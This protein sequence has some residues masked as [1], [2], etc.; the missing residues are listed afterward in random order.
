M[1]AVSRTRNQRAVLRVRLAETTQ[2]VGRAI[3]EAHAGNER[4]TVVARTCA[5]RGAG[6]GHLGV[7]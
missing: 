4:G 1:V 5:V 2:I 6:H 3:V 7:V